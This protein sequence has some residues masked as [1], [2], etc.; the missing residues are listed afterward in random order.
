MKN[1]FKAHPVGCV[2]LL[3]SIMLLPLMLMRDFTP[4]NE[5][6]YLSI[7]DEAIAEGHIFTFTNQGKPYADKPPLYFWMIMLCR[8]IFGRPSIVVLSLLSLVQ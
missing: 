4:S 3:S 5:L 6:R 1:L 2:I 7:A 8:T